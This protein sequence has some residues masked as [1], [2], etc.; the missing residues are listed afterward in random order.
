M[1]VSNP[2]FLNDMWKDISEA[3]DNLTNCEVYKLDENTFIDEVENGM[4]WSFN[5]F[6]CSKELVRIYV[7]LYL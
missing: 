4:L 6:F 7:M 2:D 3:M 5:Y 1:T